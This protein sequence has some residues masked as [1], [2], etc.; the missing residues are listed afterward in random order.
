MDLPEEE[1]WILHASPFDKTFLRNNVSFE[2]W[3]QMG[4]WAS[5][6][7]YFEL[8]LDGEYRG[9][10]ILME[11]IKRD[12]NRLDIAKLTE[13]DLAGDDVTGGY[14]IRLDWTEDSGWSSK[15]RALEE[16]FLFFQYYYP[17][18]GDIQPAQKSYIREYFNQFEEAVFSADFETNQ[19]I[20]YGIRY[21]SFINSIVSQTCLSSMN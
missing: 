10:Y 1:D 21:T 11:R 17:N 15:F 14:I 6:T 20:S 18:Q 12:K 8:V 9:L 5:N 4:Y 7:R 13:Q 2:L 16:E 19:G 3:R